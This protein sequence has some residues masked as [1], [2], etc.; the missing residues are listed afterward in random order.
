MN[1]QKTL[2]LMRSLRL[3]G[4]ADRYNAIMETPIHQRPDAV[5]ILAQL[6]EAEELYRNNRRMLS[7]IKNARF[8][9]QASLNDVI[10]SDQRNI[11]REIITSLADCSFVDRGEN[12]IITGATGCG[13]SYLASALG[14]QACTKGKKV[15]YFSLPKLLSKLKSDK[16]DGSFRKEMDR[17]ENKN[18]LILDD[19]GLTP[20]D[21]AARLAL[22]QI[23]EDRHSRYSTIITSQL[24]ISAWHQYINENTVADA[25][26]DRIIHQAHRIELKGESLRKT[27]KI[28]AG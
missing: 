18:L 15:A 12:I 25:I 27:T 21:T 9:Y 22:L 4:M 5:V 10:Y 6:V 2:E 28:Y 14:Y 19:W 23:I 11:T 17:I 1:Y 8:R 13:K 7:A 24:P 26:L 3:I 16:L 20:L